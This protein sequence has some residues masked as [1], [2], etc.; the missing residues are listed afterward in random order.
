MSAN[1]L[2]FEK[3]E[4]SLNYKERMKRDALMRQTTEAYAR[5]VDYNINRTTGFW[6]EYVSKVLSGVLKSIVASQGKYTNI[7]TYMRLDYQINDCSIF[8]C[9]RIIQEIDTYLEMVHV[10]ES[11]EKEFFIYVR[12]KAFILKN[13]LR[14]TK[15]VHLSDSQG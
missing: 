8:D 1:I 14:K 15:R 4:K 9:A 12:N 11:P 2:P 13:H 6:Y 5:R 3:P 7:D 10:Q